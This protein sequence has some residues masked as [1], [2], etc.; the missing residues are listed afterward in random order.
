VS[1]NIK[2]VNSVSEIVTLALLP[3]FLLLD[4]FGAK[5]RGG[6]TRWRRSRAFAVTALTYWL[7]L[8]VGQ[9]WE[10]WMGSTHLL[11]GAALGTPGGA[12]VGVLVCEF[13]RYWYHRL[14]HRFEW[15]WQ[16]GHQM[17]HSTEALDVCGAYYLHPF[18]AVLFTTLSSLALFPLLG[19]PP[20]AGGWAA[21]AM[22][23]L[24]FF[25]HAN[26]HTPRWLGY[27]IQR[28]ESQVV[29]RQRGVHA[30]NYADIP[31]WDMIF[32]TFRNPATASST[33]QALNG[34]WADRGRV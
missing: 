11:N 34:A 32:G 14:A 18:A 7:A 9:S 16:L 8:L 5:P 17:H 29:H 33:C 2:G 13:F 4:F 20:E 27:L 22:T 25:G 28:P 31:L 3:V 23:L 19:V 1:A 26:V 6:R 21:A 30:F 15:L 12:L 10:S 24:S